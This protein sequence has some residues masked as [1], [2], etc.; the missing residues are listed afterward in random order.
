[1]RYQPQESRPAAYQQQIY[2]DGLRGEKPRFPFDAAQW[3]PL[4]KEVLSASKSFVRFTA[5][6]TVGLQA[7]P[8]CPA[9][10]AWG[11]VHGDAGTRGTEDA[12][13]AAFKKWGLVPNRLRS[14]KQ[15]DLSTEVVGI[16]LANPLIIAPVGVRFLA[17]PER[18]CPLARGGGGC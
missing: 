18:S 8:G 10:D 3:A 4:A 11:Y 9:A 7:D 15:V 17:R 13:L 12:N 5:G 6:S 2:Q 14:F 1:M 16:K